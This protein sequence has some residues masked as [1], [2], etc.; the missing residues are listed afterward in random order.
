MQSKFKAELTRR[1]QQE[2]ENEVPDLKIDFAIVLN[3]FIVFDNRKVADTI[4][5]AQPAISN[6]MY[7]SL[8]SLDNAFL[9]RNYVG[10]TSGA[11]NQ[12]TLNPDF[13]LLTEDVCMCPFLTGNRLSG[14]VWH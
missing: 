2:F 5:A 3:K 10:T 12:K 1:L 4:F 11:V 13:K 9:V 8:S 14:N 6:K 7:G